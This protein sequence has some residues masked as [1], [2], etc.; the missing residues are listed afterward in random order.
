MVEK[1][2]LQFYGSITFVP[3]SEKSLNMGGLGLRTEA[4]G[5]LIPKGTTK[6]K[7]SLKLKRG[8]TLEEKVK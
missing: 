3:G 4:R 2:S 8:T 7:K 1:G 6:K 5:N